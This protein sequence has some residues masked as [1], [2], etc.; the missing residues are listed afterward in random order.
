MCL[1]L[2]P[3]LLETLTKDKSWQCF[4]IDLLIMCQSRYSNLYIYF[5]F[6]VMYH[7][8][9]NSALKENHSLFVYD[10]LWQCVADLFFCFILCRAIRC[11]TAEQFFLIA[12]RCSHGHRPL[13]FFITLLFTVLVV[14]V[15]RYIV[16]RHGT[17]SLFNQGGFS[18]ILR[19]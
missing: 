5:F 17:H 16:C 13:I 11:S 19:S 3:S 8:P 10:R 12:T 2:C 9:L 6:H 15:Y 14:S 1:A 7:I 4:I 18:L